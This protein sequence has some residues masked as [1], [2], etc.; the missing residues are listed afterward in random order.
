MRSDTERH[1]VQFITLSKPLELESTSSG[2]LSK[3]GKN[4]TRKRV[5]KGTAEVQ[6]L[7]KFI[8]EM[9]KNWQY[10]CVILYPKWQKTL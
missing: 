3:F 2:N 10:L 6:W 8:G 4:L 9:E 5:F 1:Q 7:T